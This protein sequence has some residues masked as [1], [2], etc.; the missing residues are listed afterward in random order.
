MWA[1]ANLGGNYIIMFTSAIVF[2]ALLVVIEADIFQ[3]CS[4]FTFRALPPMRN[5]LDMDEDVIAEQER[6][7]LQNLSRSD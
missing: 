7:T 1:L 3:K 6:L 5:D 2:T 4:N